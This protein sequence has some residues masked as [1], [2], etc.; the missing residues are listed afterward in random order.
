MSMCALFFAL[1]PPMWGYNACCNSNPLFRVDESWRGGRTQTLQFAAVLC[2][3]V[4]VMLLFLAFV[5]AGV[6]VVAC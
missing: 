6:D 2:L 5:G 4:I 1:D 3:V